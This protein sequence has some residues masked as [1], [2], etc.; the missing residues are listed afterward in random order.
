VGADSLYQRPGRRCR[1]AQSRAVE[2]RLRNPFERDG[3]LV[4]A[5]GKPQQ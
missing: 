5:I 3:F 2:T 1:F 4:S